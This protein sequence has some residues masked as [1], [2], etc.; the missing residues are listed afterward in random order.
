MTNDKTTHYINKN[1]FKSNI[2]TNSNYIHVLLPL[3]R[4]NSIIR[5]FLS[6]YPSHGVTQ[7]SNIALIMLYWDYDEN[8]EEQIDIKLHV[9][10]ASCNNTQEIKLK[11]YPNE[12][13]WIKLFE[14]PA[15]SMTTMSDTQLEPIYLELF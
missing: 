13:C 9:T 11:R 8:V 6:N 14:L 1:T 4:Y 5:F 2:K 3:E 12:Q 15:V 10:C 7:L